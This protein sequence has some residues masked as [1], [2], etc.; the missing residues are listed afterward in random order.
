MRLSALAILSLLKP[1][2]AIKATAPLS[3]D[4]AARH[5]LHSDRDAGAVSLER[6]ASIF[7]NQP[8][9]EPLAALGLSKIPL[10]LVVTAKDGSFDDL[11]R[12]MLDNI[13]QTLALNPE[14][15]VR[16]LNDAAC[17]EF[18]G[19]HFGADLLSVFNKEEHGPFRGDICRAAVIAIE[20]GFYADLDVQ[21]RVPFTRLVDNTTTFMSSFDVSCNILNAIFAAEPGSEVMYSVL[22]AIKDWYGKS[23]HEQSDSLVGT[24]SMLQG[25]GN[26]MARD[27]PQE[28]KLN[29]F[30]TPFQFQCG[31]RQS[32][33]LYR[34][35]YLNCKTKWKNG[36]ATECPPERQDGFWGLR[37]GI[38]E[39]GPAR[40]LVAY[41][42]FEDCSDFGCS[43][44][45]MPAP[46]PCS[47]R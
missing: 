19:I 7:D 11:P 33:R 6:P 43:E 9:L 21:F 29:V 37:I 5:T 40:N 32:I 16:F 2:A 8:H 44:R 23:H 13:R 34:E 38:F 17:R 25:L 27:C 18:I 46:T 1:A 14:L 10:R 4:T 45:R 36:S 35:L 3:L 41:S 12:K 24:W 26:L 47:V 15:Q 39:P 31:P 20:G 22:E 42:R 30:Y 28:D